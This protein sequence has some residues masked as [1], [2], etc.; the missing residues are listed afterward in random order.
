[1][2]ST[3]VQ[4]LFQNSLR[5]VHQIALC[6]NWVVKKSW[7]NGT[8]KNNKHFS[9]WSQKSRETCVSGYC[10]Q[11]NS[12]RARIYFRWGQRAKKVFGNE[13][14]NVEDVENRGCRWIAVN[15]HTNNWC[16]LVEYWYTWLWFWVQHTHHLKIGVPVGKLNKQTPNWQPR[17]AYLGVSKRVRKH[18]HFLIFFCF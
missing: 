14:M 7:R 12:S 10:L 13:E 16:K 8:K 5:P 4:S 17:G 2:T 18:V 6:M 15:P 11:H 9:P 1:M 3:L